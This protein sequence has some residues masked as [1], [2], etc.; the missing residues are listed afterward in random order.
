[1]ESAVDLG[2]STSQMLLHIQIP[3]MF[4]LIIPPMT[5]Q[6]IILIKESAILSIITVPELMTAA[7]KMATETFRVVEPY[8]ILAVAYWL[9]TFLIGKLASGQEEKTTHYLVN[10]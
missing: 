5:N 4:G 8:L 6:T 7:T 10:S 3:Q 1:M 9:I 2:F